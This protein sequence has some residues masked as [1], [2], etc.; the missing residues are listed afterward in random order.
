MYSYAKKA[1]LK[2]ATG[3]NASTLAATS[4]STSLKAEIVVDK[5]KSVPVD[6]NELSNVLNNEVVK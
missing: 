5:S 3:V 2:I 4:D 6:L 1:K